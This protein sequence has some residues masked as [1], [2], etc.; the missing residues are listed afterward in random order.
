MEDKKILCVVKFIRSGPIR[1]MGFILPWKILTLCIFYTALKI[2]PARLCPCGVPEDNG[3]GASLTKGE[4]PST[5]LLMRQK[6]INKALQWQAN[7]LLT[8]GG[9]EGER[10]SLEDRQKDK[11]ELSEF[12]N[13]GKQQ[14]NPGAQQFVLLPT[15]QR[16]VCLL[17]GEGRLLS[18]AQISWCLTLRITGPFSKALNA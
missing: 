1:C 9:E 10:G 14:W 11:L 16:C 2:Q 13:R 17:W 12:G 7:G 5:P 8:W 4:Q 15:L 3:V 6:L 18:I